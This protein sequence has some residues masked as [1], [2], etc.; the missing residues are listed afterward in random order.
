MI[1]TKLSGWWGQPTP[2]KKIGV[3]QLGWW[4]SQLNGKIKKNVPTHQAE[5]HLTY[6]D[7]HFQWCYI[8][9]SIHKTSALHSA[10]AIRIPSGPRVEATARSCRRLWP[11]T[12]PPALPCGLRG[13][14]SDLQ[15]R[16]RSREG[17]AKHFLEEH[18]LYPV[19]KGCESPW[20]STK[21]RLF[22]AGDEGPGV[23]EMEGGF[24][25]KAT[26]IGTDR[27]SPLIYSS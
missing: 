10:S 20:F 21:L 11:C 2:L 1:D 14:K 19:V 9:F 24:K 15:P 7:L 13:P 4:H 22:T 23:F 17:K 3:R 27:S 5:M 25:R 8:T 16:S 12:E 6:I 26:L 18:Q